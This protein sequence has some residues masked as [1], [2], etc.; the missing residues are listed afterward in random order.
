MYVCLCVCER[1]NKRKTEGKLKRQRED[2]SWGGYFDYCRIKELSGSIAL[3]LCSLLQS[4]ALSPSPFK[5]TM[6][7]SDSNSVVLLLPFL[8]FSSSAVF[9]CTWRD[10][11]LKFSWHWSASKTCALIFKHAQKSNSKSL[12]RAEHFY[13]LIF[14]ISTFIPSAATLC[15][16]LLCDVLALPHSHLLSLSFLKSILMNAVTIKT[17]R[18]NMEI[19][20]G[21][22]GAPRERDMKWILAQ[23]HHLYS[24]LE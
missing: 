14:G 5:D 17:W 2:V 24:A 18:G 23:K 10:L 20:Y 13:P 4:F 7:K 3:S 12:L 22:S 1:E 19:I 21:A 9:N 6:N 15:S 8:H 16:S 11:H